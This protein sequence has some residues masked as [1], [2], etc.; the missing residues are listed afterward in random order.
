[1][2]E[3]GA[4]SGFGLFALMLASPLAAQ[5]ADEHRKTPGAAVATAVRALPAAPKVDG[6]LDD[7]VWQ[8]APRFGSFT[9]RDPHEGQAG[10][11]TTE[12]QVVYSDAALYVGVRA[13][14]TRPE[15]IAALL[16]RRDDWSPSDEITVMIDS[17]YDRRT[18]FSFTVNAAGVKRDAYL[19][20]DNSEDGRWDAV[21]DAQVAIDSAGW[22]AEFRIPFGQLRFSRSP[23]NTF[24]FNLSRR[25]TRLNETQ[26]WRLMPRDASGAVSLFGDLT[27]LAGIEPPRRI[28]VQPYVAASN[29]ARPAVAGDPFHTGIERTATAGGDL[30]VGVTS[31][32]TLTAT[33]N[34]DFGQVEADPAVVNLS[35][36]ES[37]FAERRPFFTE[38]LDIFRFRLADGDGDGANE[39]LFY[40]RRIG[41]APQGEADPRGGYAESIAQTTILGAAKLSGKTRSGWTIGA[42]GAV[43]QAERA[44]V[45]DDAG[46]PH[47]DPVEPGTGY[48]VF[49]LARELRGGQTVIGVFGTT[50][51]R[52]LAPELD[53][54]HSSAYT[55]GI[56]WS[57]RFADNTYQVSGRVVGSRVDGSPEA[58]A[59]TQQASTHYYQRPDAEHLDFDPTRTS[60]SG[61]TVALNGGR[62]AGNWRFNVGG[63]ARSP[64]FEVNDL[65]FQRESDRLS[66]GVWIN[67]RWLTPGS[68]FRRFNLNLNQWAGWTFGGERRS[69]GANFNVNFTTLNYW[70]GWFGLNRN[71]EGLSTTALRGGPAIRTPGNV[72]GWFGLSTDDRRAVSADVFGNFNVR[73]EGAG[74]N[75]GIGFGLAWRPSSNVELR[76]GP[77]FN[78]NKD[79][80]QYLDTPTVEGEPVYLFGELTQR[81]ASLTLRSNV[82]FSPSL[83]LQVY[84]QP[85]VSSGSYQGFKRVT[86]PRADRFAD[87]FDP[88]GGAATRGANGEV[89]IDVDQDGATD[90]T[91]ENPDF[92]VLSL[93]SN[94]VLRW[95]YLLGSTLFLVW[96]HGRSD[97]LADGRFRFGERVGDIF[98][99]P[100]SNV[101]LV[102]LNYWLSL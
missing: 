82:T 86:A 21:W 42:L 40:T 83:S 9:Q 8:T 84:A 5:G 75:A 56:N 79:A 96:Q 101:L 36:F 97:Y 34:P 74:T 46:L 71:L 76:L 67:R 16:S 39:E 33:I 73:D 54:L 100:S 15:Q 64:G 59:R 24:G 52:S 18:G 63:E 70:G 89:T 10:T 14:D 45:V 77:N 19:F 29:F 58:I 47:R 30:K 87:R 28:E 48:G 66:Q 69:F 60:L 80:W 38:G 53:W 85:F 43:T 1:M 94:V 4:W 55:G 57:H 12:F 78:Y 3:R 51:Q 35:A 88:F 32:L 81:T 27:G 50:V 31:G 65:G 23:S 90:L 37:F 95:E 91:L 98:R 22:T 72:N 92:T 49:R 99:S 93:R 41:R 6:R 2:I 25:I 26:Q 13:A 68:V 20:N 17:Y 11:E 61:Y 7:P 102:K 44:R 62:T